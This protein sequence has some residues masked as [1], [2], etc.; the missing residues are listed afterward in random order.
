MWAT[1]PA[2]CLRTV[3]RDLTPLGQ[4]V[5]ASA[6]DPSGEHGQARPAL[7]DLDREIDRH[8]EIAERHRR[9]HHA[10]G[11]I[12]GLLGHA[13]VGTRAY[14][15]TALQPVV[16]ESSERGVESI[17]FDDIHQQHSFNEALFSSRK[18]DDLGLPLPV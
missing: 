17:L 2:Y 5:A 3:G 13:E 7:G 15:K 11:D 16:G 8:E 4:V 12:V 10:A 6:H 14:I 18:R 9:H 1:V